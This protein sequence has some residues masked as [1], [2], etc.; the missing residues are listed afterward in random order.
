[1]WCECEWRER[2]HTEVSDVFTCNLMI[3]YIVLA[4]FLVH[5]VRVAT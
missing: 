1:M 4:F 3:L 2:A 5:R